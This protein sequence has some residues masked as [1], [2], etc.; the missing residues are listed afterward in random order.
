[1]AGGG[2]GGARQCLRSQVL[3]PPWRRTR[4]RTRRIGTCC[5]SRT[6]PLRRALNLDSADK[7]VEELFAFLPHLP[8]LNRKKAYTSKLVRPFPS[9]PRLVDGFGSKGLTLPQLSPEIHP[10]LVPPVPIYRD[11]ARHFVTTVTIVARLF[12]LST[13]YRVK[14]VDNSIRLPLGAFERPPSYNSLN[15][16]LTLNRAGANV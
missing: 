6:S 10:K 3:A 11:S 12:A 4:R 7:R 2:A 16:F 13:R 8:L 15:F 1:M 14:N 5:R 9:P